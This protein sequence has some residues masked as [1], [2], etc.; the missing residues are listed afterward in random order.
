MPQFKNQNDTVNGFPNEFLQY[1]H[2]PGGGNQSDVECRLSELTEEIREL[3]K[4]LAPPSAVIIT[5][6]DAIKEFKKLI[7]ETK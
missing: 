1:L 3:R 7:K 2:K 4:M 6:Q 5:G